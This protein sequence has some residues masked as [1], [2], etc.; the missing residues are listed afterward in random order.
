MEVGWGR[1]EVG[2]GEGEV[3]CG[4]EGGGVEIDRG[5][6]GSRTGDGFQDWKTNHLCSPGWC[7]PAG[8]GKAELA[9]HTRELSSQGFHLLSEIS[10]L[11]HFRKK[12]HATL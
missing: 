8:L 4:R 3:G 10:H 2:R 7:S 11:L 6:G 12:E 9:A 1:K 5:R